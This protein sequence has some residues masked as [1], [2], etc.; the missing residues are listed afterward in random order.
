MLEAVWSMGRA[1]AAVEE[2]ARIRGTWDAAV[3]VLMTV[4]TATGAQR[5]LLMQKGALT[6]YYLRLS[7]SLALEVLRELNSPGAAYVA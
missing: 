2:T 5:A 6:D 7:A 3:V 4:R 1:E